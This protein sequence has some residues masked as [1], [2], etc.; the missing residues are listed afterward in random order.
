MVHAQ[1]IPTRTASEHYTPPPFCALF[2]PA[3][4]LWPDTKRTLR[5]IKLLKQ[6]DH[7][8]VIQIWDIVAPPSYAE[9]NDLYIV[10]ELMQ[11]DVRDILLFDVVSLV[12]VVCLSACLSVCPPGLGCCCA[13]GFLP[14]P[15]PLLSLPPPAS[16][17]LHR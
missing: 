1:S 13:L 12:A 2:L 11:T 14:L 4:T 16:R 5:E 10:M 17:R 3:T 6:L 9:F 8:Q 15:I 7:D